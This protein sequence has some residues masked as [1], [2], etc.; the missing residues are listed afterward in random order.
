MSNKREV[1]N[2]LLKNE[3]HWVTRA[4]IELVGGVEGMRRLR[5]IRSDA[6]AAGY[7][8]KSRPTGVKGAD[9]YM[10]LKYETHISPLPF[11]CVKCG[12]GPVGEMRKSTDM[13]D[14]WRWAKCVVCDETNSLFKRVDP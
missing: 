10:I 7:I 2:L 5:E 11:A 14:R 12:N 9:E 8:V 1:W 3:G 4:A 13:A 6:Y